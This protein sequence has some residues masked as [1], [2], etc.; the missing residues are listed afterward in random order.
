MCNDETC[1]GVNSV[2]VNEPT[3]LINDVLEDGA[4]VNYE[5][6]METKILERNDTAK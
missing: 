4:V 2:A 1:S 6:A 5:K 3:Q